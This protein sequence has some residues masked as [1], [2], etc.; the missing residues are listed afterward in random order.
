MLSE[1]NMYDKVEYWMKNRGLEPFLIQRVELSDEIGIFTAKVLISGLP[2]DFDKFVIHRTNGTFLHHPSN[3]LIYEVQK[4]SMVAGKEDL[5][6]DFNFAH[7]I[8]MH[9]SGISFEEIRE[10][11]PLALIAVLRRQKWYTNKKFKGK[12][13]EGEIKKILREIEINIEE[14][15]EI[16]L[17]D[18]SDI[19]SVRF[20]SRAIAFW[21]DRDH[22]T[23]DDVEKSVLLYRIVLSRII[24]RIDPKLA[25]E[26]K[27]KLDMDELNKILQFTE[28]FDLKKWKNVEASISEISSRIGHFYA[29]SKIESDLQ[30]KIKE[31]IEN[32]KCIECGIDAKKRCIICLVPLCEDHVFYSN[33]GAIY[34]KK[35]GEL[36]FSGKQ[37]E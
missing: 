33:E 15:E 21:Q 9:V 12:L 2:H 20:L 37:I 1:D 31:N 10:Y 22:M 24:E 23:S 36:F 26:I 32:N 5:E 19:H 11:M 7:I 27:P 16:R 14:G 18:I 4:K 17:D 34:C 30:D 6:V 35:H 8:L 29:D 28:I 3:K 13:L 25:A